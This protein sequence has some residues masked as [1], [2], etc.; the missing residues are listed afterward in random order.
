[1][2]Q[3]S[4]PSLPA[5]APQPGPRLE[6]LDGLRA[7]AAMYVLLFH[8]SSYQWA[9]QFGRAGLIIKPFLYGHEAVD[10]FIVLS[11]FSLMLPIVQGDGALR[12]GAGA[13]FARRARRILPPYYAA[14]A[15]CLVLDG[16]LLARKT[17]GAWD[18]AVP[19]TLAGVLAHL[20][21]V[22]D[23]F[24]STGSQI[25]PPMWSVSVEWRIYF[26]FPLLVWAWRR[27][28]PWATVGLAFAAAG[29]FSFA[30]AHVPV[31]EHLNAQDSGISPQYLG[32]FALGMLGAGLAFS[33]DPRLTRLHQPG[34]RAAA[35]LACAA[36]LV[37]IH[38]LPRGLFKTDVIAGA[39]AVAVIV[40]AA[41]HDGWLRR[42]LSWRPL[43]RIGTFAYSLYL[44]H[45]AC[46]QL[47]WQYVV[48]PLHLAWPLEFAAHALIGLPAALA[49]SYL[50]F[51]VCER[52]FL[53]RRKQETAAEEAQDA[54]LSPAP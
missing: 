51:L 20:F 35:V 13:F 32:L 16:T 18:S 15:L 4:L 31:L 7:L 54:A 14:L 50:F 52:P 39:C 43:V 22:Q 8:A 48:H 9:H 28:G 40:S 45:F 53:V 17:G 5:A 37:G 21:L 3:T 41:R 46:L 11:G 27:L 42:A 24:A 47:V 23:A 2:P 29:V 33:R 12:G 25:N 36:A 10:L 19:V 30:F 6:F 34:L 44:L 1:M 38:F 26:C 49:A